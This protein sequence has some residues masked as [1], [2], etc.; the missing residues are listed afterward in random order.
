MK[1]VG[2]RNGVSGSCLGF[3]VASQ[4]EPV[5]I[6][7]E[8]QVHFSCNTSADALDVLQDGNVDWATQGKDAAKTYGEGF[9]VCNQTFCLVKLS[10]CALWAE[11]CGWL[12][13]GAN[14]APK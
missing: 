7:R 1:A 14:T 4:D 13:G 8:F 9:K 5:A 6:E 11:S 10:L 3:V 2:L 12:Q